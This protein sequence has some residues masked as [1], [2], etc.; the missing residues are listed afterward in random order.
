M[1][2]ADMPAMPAG[3]EIADLGL[4]GVSNVADAIKSNSGLTKRE[5]FAM[6]AM[7]GLLA[8]NSGWKNSSPMTNSEI[9]QEAVDL[10]D[11]L[12]EAL[13]R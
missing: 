2:N 8:A 12:L 9:V 3:F 1:K 10:A 5:K 13:E 11:D 7:Q 4:L 6:H